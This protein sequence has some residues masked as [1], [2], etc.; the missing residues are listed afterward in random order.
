MRESL[1]FGAFGLLFPVVLIGKAWRRYDTSARRVLIVPALSVTLLLVA[2]PHGL[3]WILLGPD[4]SN[5]LYLTIGAN[6]VL[7]FA[8]A[9]YS[10]FKRRWMA[11][12]A[13]A[14]LALAWF[15]VGAIN[16]VA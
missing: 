7:A 4:Y 12:V 16:S 14:F 3:R 13:S 9:I 11:L 10:G 15:W 5:R 6:V 2:I 8:S 1:I